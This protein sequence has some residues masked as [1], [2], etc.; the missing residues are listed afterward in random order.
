MGRVFIYDTTLRDGCQ[1]A[2]ISLSLH[3]KLKIARRL[4][5]LGIDY[6]EGGWPG[7]NPKDAQFFEALL[8]APLRQAKVTAFGSTRRAGGRVDDDVNL[9]L[10]IEAGTPAVALVAKSWDYHV[11]T[12]LRT[13][14]I[15][16]LAM[17]SES[18]RYL[19]AQGREVIFDAEHFFDG[20]RANQAYALAVLHVAAEAGA[21]W[22]VLCDTNGGALSSQVTAVVRSVLSELGPMIGIHTH[23]DG[24]LAVANTLAAVDAGARQ[25]QGT[26][27]GYGERTGNANLCSIIPNLVLKMGY[28][29]AIGEQ[30]TQLT[31]LSHFVDEVANVVPNRRL[32]FVG[33]ASFAHKAG[34]HAHAVAIDARTYEH[35]D[36]VRVGNER[37]VLISELSG[38][39]NVLEKA[40]QF[41]L[42]LDKESPAVRAVVARIK[43]LESQ[44]FQFEDAEASFELLVRRTTPEYRPP[45]ELLDFVVLSE[46]RGPAEIV[47]EATVKLRVNNE[48]LHTA[49]EGNGPVNALDQAMRKALL[50]VYPELAAVTLT[51]YKVRVLETDAGTAAAVRVWI[52]TTGPDGLNWYTVG[53]ATNVIQA[54]WLALADSLEYALTHARAR[55]AVSA[56][57]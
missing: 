13:T 53:S 44:G 30:L 50:P 47:A 8:A 51:D 9:R 11:E 32:P 19:K 49:A 55:D 26:V 28:Q 17:I 1:A 57:R 24:D 6:I 41:G 15:E 22:L 16:N 20:Y 39:G 7:S 33:A 14:L 52:Q 56:S 27:N 34:I 43:E 10:L 25:V 42:E 21:D 37:H 23:N 2:G 5:E 48:V 18:V 4:D 31:A 36:P 38:R 45:F 3:D 46:K 54:S 35:I 29:C 40:R 12:V